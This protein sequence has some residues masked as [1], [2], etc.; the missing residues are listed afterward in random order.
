MY[1]YIIIIFFSYCF[2]NTNT[3]KKIIRKNVYIT[4]CFSN[5]QYDINR[6][7]AL[8]GSL[9]TL[10][11]KYPLFVLLTENVINETENKFKIRNISTIRI[12]FIE[13]P[14]EMFLQFD[15]WNKTFS[16]LYLWNLEEYF[17]TIIWLDS[18]LFLLKNIDHLFRK[19][20]YEE[21]KIIVSPDI[22]NC[23]TFN[24]LLHYKNQTIY[25]FNI[26]VNSGLMILKPNHTIYNLLVK[27]LYNGTNYFKG[28]Q[29]VI[30]SVYNNNFHFL[31]K[32]YVIFPWIL[33]NCQKEIKECIQINKIHAIH[34]A[35]DIGPWNNYDKNKKKYN[36]TWIDR[37]TRIWKNRFIKTMFL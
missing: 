1:L 16:K 18:D 10:K 25:K 33:C 14:K 27:N 22:D 11:M 3:D 34:F 4:G 30:Q 36:C 12:P 28:D 23:E 35:T 9:F 31:P 6:V 21:H 2:Y 5:E 29:Q 15:R 24:S 32:E 37:I 8:Q 13:K 20:Q 26:A 17:D 7:F 19:K